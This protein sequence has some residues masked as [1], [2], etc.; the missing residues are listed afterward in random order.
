MKKTLI[1]MT[2]LVIISSANRQRRQ[3]RD[4]ERDLGHQEI[5]EIVEDE[6]IHEDDP[7]EIMKRELN[8]EWDTHMS[9]F[10]PE[11][12]ISAEI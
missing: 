10:V 11:D 6:T 1:I 8:E 4:E 9:D 2:L 12:M 5:L 3:R 7:E